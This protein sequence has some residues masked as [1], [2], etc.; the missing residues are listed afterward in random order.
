MLMI[1]YVPFDDL[2]HSF[3]KSKASDVFIICLFIEEMVYTPA[4]LQSLWSP[5]AMCQIVLL[6][7]APSSTSYVFII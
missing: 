7:F 3:D 2:M 5:D 4:I 6:L 1:W